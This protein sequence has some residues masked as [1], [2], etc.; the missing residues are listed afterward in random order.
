LKEGD[1][2][3][4]K[5]LARLIKMSSDKGLNIKKLDEFGLRI[6]VLRQFE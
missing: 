4:A 6:N 2:F 3:P 5:N 1:G